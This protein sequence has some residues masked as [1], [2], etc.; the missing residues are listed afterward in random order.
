MG[1]YDG[2]ASGCVITG[3]NDATIEFLE[4]SGL[5]FRNVMLRGSINFGKC[6]FFRDVS[7]TDL[8]LQRTPHETY[9]CTVKGSKASINASVKHASRVEFESVRLERDIAFGV[10]VTSKIFAG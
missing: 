7:I 8:T 1:A 10:C 4:G 3:Q 9:E 6:G 2:T 5:Q